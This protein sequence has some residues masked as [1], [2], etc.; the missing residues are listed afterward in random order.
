M[1]KKSTSKAVSRHSLFGPPPILEGEDAA[2]YDELF[3]RVCAAI[4]PVDVID[5]MLAN[6]V[7]CLQ[8]EILRLRR[9]KTSL[10]RAIGS[11]A[12]EKFLSGVLDYDLYRVDFEETLAETL[13]ENLAEDQPEDFAQ[14]LARRCARNEPDAVEKVNKLLD[15]AGLDMDRILNIAENHKV[16][17]LVQGY[18]QRLPRAIKQVTKLLA[19]SGRTMDDLL[20]NEVTVIGHRT[21]HLAIMERIDHL[22]TIAETRRNAT[23][24]EIDRH[25]AVLGEALRRNLQE[26]EGQYEVIER[27]PA[28][29]KSAA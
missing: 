17:Q 3:G 25:R 10:I 27:T 15:A 21:D 5:E 7:V 26:V 8:W 28:E 2:A 16:E 19:S 1:R 4:K 23:F 24:R 6:D 11:K 22:I 9:L 20:A 12:L 14:E 13:Q 29:A 18:A